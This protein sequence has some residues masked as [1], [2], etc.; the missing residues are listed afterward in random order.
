MLQSFGHHRQR[1]RPNDGPVISAIG[2]IPSVHGVITVGWA[3]AN[4]ACVGHQACRESTADV[5]GGLVDEGRELRLIGGVDEEM[6]ET[7]VGV[8]DLDFRKEGIVHI[9]TVQGDSI[10]I[11]VPVNG[12][13][14]V[15]AGKVD[16]IGV[17]NH[18]LDG[19]SLRDC[20][21]ERS[22]TAYM[23]RRLTDLEELQRF[24]L[25]DFGVTVR[26]LSPVLWIAIDPCTRKCGD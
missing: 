14:L 21:L 8:H 12:V 6:A 1:P 16:S 4:H 26:T 25:P 5:G 17:V 22:A 18:A 7:V 19:V 9:R 13:C 15:G 10:E 11:D 23:F 20:N 2:E 24:V 3:S